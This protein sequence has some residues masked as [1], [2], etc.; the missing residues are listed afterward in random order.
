MDLQEVVDDDDYL[1][2]EVSCS[3]TIMFQHL[4]F[5]VYFVNIK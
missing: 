5:S 1:R 2:K 4:N 3:N